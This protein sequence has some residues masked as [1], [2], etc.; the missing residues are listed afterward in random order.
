MALG[1]WA[2]QGRVNGGKEGREEEGKGGEESE[3]E[4]GRGNGWRGQYRKRRGEERRVERKGGLWSTASAQTR[5]AVGLYL[6]HRLRLSVRGAD[7]AP[8]KA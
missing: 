2:P 5:H 1:P 6:Y 7:D 8:F 3:K 4:W